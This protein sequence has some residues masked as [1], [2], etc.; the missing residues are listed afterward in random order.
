MKNKTHKN[1]NKNLETKNMIMLFLSLINSIKLFHWKTNIYSAHKAS[2][3]LF[4]KISENIDKF[5]EILLGKLNIKPIMDKITC[6]KIQNLKSNKE[7]E[8]YVKSIKS[9]LISLDNNKLLRTM[10]NTDLYNIRDEILGDLN[11]FL[12]LLTLK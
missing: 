5:V 2:D 4:G 1:I 8:N 12:Y 11:Q 10:S 9:Y 7:C 6:I 3:E